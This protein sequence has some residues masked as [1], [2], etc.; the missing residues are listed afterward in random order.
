MK[1]KNIKIQKMKTTGIYLKESFLN[2]H[3]HY[4]CCDKF[5][6]PFIYSAGIKSPPEI[7]THDLKYPFRN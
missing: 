3:A 6:A 1:N 2:K 4:D 5:S 7:C